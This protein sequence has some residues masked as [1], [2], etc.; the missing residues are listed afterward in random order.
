MKDGPKGKSPIGKL[1]KNSKLLITIVISA[2]L[3]IIIAGMV[4]ILVIQ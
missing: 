1:M 2:V 4:Y 3:M